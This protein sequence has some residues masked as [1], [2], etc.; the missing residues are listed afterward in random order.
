MDMDRGT[1][2]IALRLDRAAWEW[3]LAKIE[4]VRTRIQV[5]KRKAHSNTKASSGETEAGQRNGQQSSGFGASDDAVVEPLELGIS[6]R[7]SK[8]AETAN[9]QVGS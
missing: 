5:A 9:T 4:Q 2:W 6:A 1:D 3:R 8:L 7:C